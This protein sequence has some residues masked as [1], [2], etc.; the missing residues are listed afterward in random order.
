MRKKM[1]L[2]Y[3]HK[4][5]DSGGGWGWGRWC[6]RSD[7]IH[8]VKT[9][10]NVVLSWGQKSG[11]LRGVCG[12]V[13]FGN[14]SDI[15]FTLLFDRLNNSARGRTADLQRYSIQHCATLRRDGR[16]E[17]PS[18]MKAGP[19]DTEVVYLFA[20]SRSK[21]HL[22][23]L[24]DISASTISIRIRPDFVHVSFWSS[25][26]SAWRLVTQRNNL[27]MVGH[28]TIF[29]DRNKIF[30]SLISGLTFLTFMTTYLFSQRH[31]R[32]S[33]ERCIQFRGITRRRWASSRSKIEK[34]EAHRFVSYWNLHL[35]ESR[36]Q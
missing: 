21:F 34:C 5:E 10:Q 35:S 4:C 17:K 2:I 15:F 16:G 24:I 22:P 31:N 26:E 3:Q 27:C 29:V 28:V 20:E 19:S 33:R 11:W 23:H 30:S 36:L 1:K 18:R 9:K 6:W 8:I 13:D 14:I 32:Y 7:R 25:R 12:R